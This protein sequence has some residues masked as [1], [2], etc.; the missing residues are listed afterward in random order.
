[1]FRYNEITGHP[2]DATRWL[3]DAFSGKNNFGLQGAPGADSD[4]YQNIVMRVYDD[5]LEAEGGGRNVRVWGNYVSD[6]KVAIG[7]ATVHYGPTYVW[8]NVINRIRTCYRVDTDNDWNSSAFKFA[9][10]KNGFG[11][12]MR[13]LFHNTLLQQ[14][15]P[16]GLSDTLGAGTGIEGDGGGEWSVRWTY[17]RNNIFHVRSPNNFS[18]ITGDQP[19]GTDFSFNVF[20]GRYDGRLQVPDPDFKFT[21]SSSVTELFYKSGH[22]PSSAP[23][24]GGN[25]TGNYQLEA[26]S[27]GQD[28]WAGSNAC[29]VIPTFNDGFT[30]SAPDCGAHENGAPPMKFGISAGQ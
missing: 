29:E 4:I 13:Y 20:N 23:Q 21:N 19:V 5:A 2:T 6:T 1:V 28:A 7:T 30:G 15:P 26:G 9:G 17:A 25:G 3:M 11:D 12:G 8:R 14:S 27:K 24:L 10:K 22:G 16:S 18:V